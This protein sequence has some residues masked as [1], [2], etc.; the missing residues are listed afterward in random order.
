MVNLSLHILANLVHWHV[1]RTF[2]ERLYV[3]VPCTE[4]EF[5]H[6]VEFGKLSSVISVSDATRTET[7]AE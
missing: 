1:S 5:A 7:V 4:N 6:S 3:L 2:D